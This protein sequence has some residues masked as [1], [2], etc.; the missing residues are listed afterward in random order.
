MEY[1]TPEDLEQRPG[2]LECGFIAADHDHELRLAGPDVTAGHRY[3]EDVVYQLPRGEE[4]TSERRLA[5]RHLDQERPARGAGQDAES[6]STTSRTSVPTIV[7]TTVAFCRH[8]GRGVPPSGA[9]RNQAGQRALQV[10]C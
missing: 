6:P 9:L 7:K 2:P 4:L 3:V 5:R 1:E 10:P 8:L